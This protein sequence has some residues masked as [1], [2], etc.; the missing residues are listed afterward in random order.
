MKNRTQKKIQ[1]AKAI[2]GDEIL[3][4]AEVSAILRIPASTLYDL[5]R[6]GKIRSVKVGRHW[7]FFAKDI[8]ALLR[9]TQNSAKS[10][11]NSKKRKVRRIRAEISAQLSGILSQTQTI[12]H[13]G[14]IQDISES[15]IYFSIVTGN[16]KEQNELRSGDP[17]KIEF[18]LDEPTRQSIVLKGCIIREGHGLNKGYG[19]KFRQLSKEDQEIIRDY[20]G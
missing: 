17:V 15:G 10:I 5:A 20:V 12:H 1:N 16:S 2:T 6:Q 13:Q 18:E 14:V 11:R 7:R 9:G 8:Q 4:V 3:N 19:I